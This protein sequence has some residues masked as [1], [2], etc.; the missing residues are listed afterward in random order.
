M[1]VVHSRNIYF[2][3]KY[4]VTNRKYNYEQYKQYCIVF[5][6]QYSAAQQTKIFLGFLY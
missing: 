5:T 2:L 6:V 1:T 3:L 4:S